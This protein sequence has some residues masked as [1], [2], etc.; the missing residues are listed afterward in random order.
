MNFPDKYQLLPPMTPQ[1]FEALKADIAQRGVVVPIDVD[2]NGDILDG[3]NRYRAWL[4][5]KKNEPPPMIVRTGMTEQ[6][7]RSFARKNNILRRHL[8]REQ[9]R[10]LIA[11]QLK[12]SPD[13][14]DNRIAEEL[15]VDGKTVGSVRDDLESTSEFPKL[16]RLVGKDGKSRPRKV[17]RIKHPREIEDDDDDDDEAQSDLTLVK[18]LKAYAKALGEPGDVNDLPDDVKLQMFAV[19]LSSGNVIVSKG[20]SPSDAARERLREVSPEQYAAHERCADFMAKTDPDR[21]EYIHDYH[22]WMIRNGWSVEAWFGPEGEEWRSRGHKPRSK[23]AEKKRKAMLR[24][25]IDAGVFGPP[26]FDGRSHTT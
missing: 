14:A 5:L 1:A 23:L 2:E 3:H 18:A 22:D 24:A 25:M 8:T 7:K 10:D 20:T 12:D 11:E 19:G 16:D 9:I 21:A 4:E 17:P 15:G 13:W 26:V 6:E